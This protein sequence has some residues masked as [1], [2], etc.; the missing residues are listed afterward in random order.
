MGQTAIVTYSVR[1]ND[2]AGGQV[3][4][5]VVTSAAPGANCPPGNTD[6]R[7]TTTVTVLRPVMTISKTATCPLWSSAAPS[8]TRSW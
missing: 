7:C 6:A 2:T 5:N 4:T 8:A 1:I 3:L